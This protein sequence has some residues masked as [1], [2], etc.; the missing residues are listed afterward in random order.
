MAVHRQA[1][2][3]QAEDHHREH[4]GQELAGPG[5]TGE[6]AADVA[7]H[8]QAIGTLE[9][10]EDEPHQIVEDMVQ[11]GDDQQAVKHAKEERADASAVEQQLAQA[12]DAVLQRWPDQAEQQAQ[13]NG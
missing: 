9:T 7:G 2:G 8:G 5:I 11:A 10:P 4:P 12:V 1:R 6:I 13:A 3:G